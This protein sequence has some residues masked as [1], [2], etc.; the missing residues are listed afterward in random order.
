MTAMDAA[1]RNSAEMIEQL[2]LYMN[3]VRQAAITREIIEVVSGAQSAQVA[4]S[5]HSQLPA[6]RRSWTRTETGQLKTGSYKDSD[7]PAIAAEQK[8]GKVVQVIGPV[9]DI[10][11]EGGHLPAIYNA[12][13]ITSERQG[14]RRSTSSSRSSSTSARTACARSR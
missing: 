1:T 12:V 4:A 6:R 11:F 7:M 10:E 5:V 8:V 3:K 9:V 2:T 13:R 14:G